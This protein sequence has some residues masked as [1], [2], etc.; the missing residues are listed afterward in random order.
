MEMCLYPPSPQATRQ[1]G[2][3][4]PI[5]LEIPPTLSPGYRC[6][7][8]TSIPTRKQFRKST[9]VHFTSVLGAYH[10][11][12][13]R[14]NKNK[15]Y[16]SVNNLLYLTPLPPERC[17]NDQTKFFNFES[18]IFRYFV[19]FIYVMMPQNTEGL[20]IFIIIC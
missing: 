2:C 14:A 5:R 20:M 16:F 19:V 13:S 12:T 8:S 17:I 4:R 3:P 15:L 7:V 9:P 1:V 11:N 18:K 6:T 10:W